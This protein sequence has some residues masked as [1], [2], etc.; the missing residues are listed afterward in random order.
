MSSKCLNCG[1][2]ISLAFCP[3]CGQKATGS[4]RSL[5]SIFSDFFGELFSL[6]G[7]W[8]RTA[9]VLMSPGRLTELYLAGKRAS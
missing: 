8:P 5:R 4:R 9:L 6:D 1:E 7:R 3:A 2:P